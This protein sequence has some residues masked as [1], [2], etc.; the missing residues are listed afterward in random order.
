MGFEGDLPEGVEGV[1]PSFVEALYERFLNDPAS[2]DQGWR[3]YFEGLESSVRNSGPSWARTDWPPLPTDPLVA[4]LDPTQMTAEA[5]TPERPAKSAK[6]EKPA[7]APY[8]ALSADELRNAADASIRAMTLIR[9]YRVRGHLAAS[10]DPL[11]LDGSRSEHCEADLPGRRSRSGIGDGSGDHRH[12][13]PQL[14]RQPRRRVH[15]HQRHRGA[16]L[17]PGTRRGS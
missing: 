6:S 1:G 13:A 17:H 4:A 15:A 5:P 11:G 8:V 10:L 12:P 7:G 14:L 3:R 9:S 2:I 16:A